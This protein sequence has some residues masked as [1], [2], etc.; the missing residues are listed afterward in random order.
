MYDLN[1]YNL[2]NPHINPK[3]SQAK[4]FAEWRAEAR[5]EMLKAMAPGPVHFKDVVN[6]G[7]LSKHAGTPDNVDY[8]WYFWA[9]ALSPPH[10]IEKLPDGLITLFDVN[11]TMSGVF[12]HGDKE[13][14][15]IQ[16]DLAKMTRN[17]RFKTSTI[18]DMATKYQARGW[19]TAD[20]AHLFA[21]AV[22]QTDKYKLHTIDL[23][24]WVLN[25]G[26]D[27]DKLL[28]D[29]YYNLCQHP[30]TIGAIALFQKL[31]NDDKTELV[32][33]Y[34]IMQMSMNPTSEFYDFCQSHNLNVILTPDKLLCMVKT[35]NPDQ[36]AHAI[37]AHKT[38]G[39]YTPT[40]DLYAILVHKC[41]HLVP[42]SAVDWVVLD[43]VL[44]YGSIECIHEMLGRG[45]KFQS[46]RQYRIYA[47]C[48]ECYNGEI[49]T[50]NFRYITA[51]YVCRVRTNMPLNELAQ[52]NAIN[53]FWIG[54]GHCDGPAS[55][56]EL[57]TV[58]GQTE[59]GWNEITE[60]RTYDIAP[61][62]VVRCTTDPATAMQN[63]IPCLYIA[64]NSE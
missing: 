20:A 40:P 61:T 63:N 36:C 35:L 55:N 6:T 44:F 60:Q 16:Y 59:T 54:Y 29:I 1:T 4:F 49:H 41:P 25:L 7:E 53:E 11:F 19:L 24:D 9:S 34:A 43:S 5:L 17:F 27:Y 62:K 21:V 10:A 13:T 32:K 47:P 12:K 28:P 46:D 3:M 64:I 37:T 30:S 33:K 50:C 56:V 14:I 51:D 52:A 26:L 42:D 15:T 2:H 18:I 39:V 22:F 58:P 38:T 48:P 57:Y 31:M 8:E 23:F 45:F